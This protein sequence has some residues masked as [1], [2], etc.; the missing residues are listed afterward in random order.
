[1]SAWPLF[2]SDL[3]T[4]CIDLSVFWGNFEAFSRSHRPWQLVPVPVGWYSLGKV[5]QSRTVGD[6]LAE[7]VSI[8]AKP[9]WA[10]EAEQSVASPQRSYILIQKMRRHWCCVQS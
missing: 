4:T 5:Q 6:G 8:P 10:Q 3:D 7:G 2:S 9:Y 1:M